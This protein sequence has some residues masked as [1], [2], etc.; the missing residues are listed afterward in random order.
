M[1]FIAGDEV[2]NSREAYPTFHLSLFTFHLLSVADTT[3]FTLPK[4]KKTALAD[5][6]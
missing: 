4:Q 6:L 5:S 3:P 2:F 1:Q